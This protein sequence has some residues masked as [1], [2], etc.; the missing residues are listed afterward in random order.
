MPTAMPSMEASVPVVAVRPN[1]LPSARIAAM[2]TPTPTSAVSSGSP[3][4]AREPKVISSTTAASAKPMAS[5]EP[6]AAGGE[7][8]AL[9]PTSTVRP[10][11]RASS[12]DFSRAVL[13]ES[14][15]SS[16]LTLKL[17]VAYAVEASS[18]TASDRK[19]LVTEAT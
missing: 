6:P 4:A 13:L 14:V 5:A 2:V 17:T 16:A 11:S 12:T 19:G 10:A 3:A 1:V 7:A 9:P 18:L 15:R 8:S